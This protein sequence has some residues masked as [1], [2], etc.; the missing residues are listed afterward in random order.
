MRR[1]RPLFCVALFALA[2]S[3]CDSLPTR[4]STSPEQEMAERLYAEGDFPAAAQAFLDA[5]RRSRAQ[6]DLLTLRAA[7]A[8][9]EDGQIEEAR[10]LLPMIG[11]RRLDADGLLRIN[12]LRAELALLDRDPQRT[13]DVLG[14]PIEAIPEAQRDRV[15]FLRAQAFAGLDQP[16][17]AARERAALEAWLPAAERAENAAAIASLLGQVRPAELQRA[18]AGLRRG[19]PLYDHAAS[20]LRALGLAMPSAAGRTGAGAGS[21]ANRVA[22]L[23]PRSGALA[24][25][26]EAVRDGFMTGY[27]ADAGERPEVVLYDA[28]DSVED[29]LQAYRDASADGVDRI[30][31]PLSREAIT[32]LFEMGTLQ[33][34]VLA[35]NRGTVTPPPGSQSFA[36]SPE[37]EG[38]AAAERILELGYRRILVANGGDEHARRVLAALVP[39]FARGGGSVVTELVPPDGSPDYSGEIRRAIAAAGTRSPEA[40]PETP[41]RSGAVL[42]DVDAIYLAVR[43]EQARLLVPQLRSAGIFDRPLLA[44]SQIR[45]ADGT[46]RPDRDFD[47]IEFTELPW[48]LGA[49]GPGLPSQDDS[50]RLG[51]AQGASARLFA[52]GLDAYRV[53]AALP[54][55]ARMP[56]SAIDGASGSLSLDEFGQIQ[57]RPGWG[58]FQDARAQP[59]PSEQTGLQLDGGAGLR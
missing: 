47:G 1:L 53:L 52:F 59:I 3:G 28:G 42:I 55:L 32:A 38:V 18:S 12:L 33:T 56:G 19:D 41:D 37:D 22:L 8:W 23:L 36:L 26:G 43:F 46:A 51:T 6:R 31:G 16:F 40:V 9:R 14:Q 30:V 45:G 2:L 44:S 13:L 17:E 39:T 25:A 15:Y 49:S 58:R 54:A 10:A 34:P 21:R 7:E 11:E 5:A 48:L 20:Q 24:A 57:R 29:N 50:R 4:A 27:Y 35:L